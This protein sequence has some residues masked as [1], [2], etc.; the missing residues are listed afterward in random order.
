[1]GIDKGFTIYQPRQ[2]VVER[3]DMVIPGFQNSLVPVSKNKKGP[4]ISGTFVFIRTT[5]SLKPKKSLI[6]NCAF[7]LKLQVIAVNVFIH[8][9]EHIIHA[10]TVTE[11]CLYIP[12]N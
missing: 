3:S 2:P 5:Q 10:F 11:T 7:H 6:K 12:G 1:M 9:G 8:K 4:G